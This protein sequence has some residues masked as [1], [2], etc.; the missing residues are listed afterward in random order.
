M[1]REGGSYSSLLLGVTEQSFHSAREGF[2]LEQTNMMPD[3][4]RGLTRRQPSKMLAETLVGNSG[5]LIDTVNT[6]T[7][8]FRTFVYDY[9]GKQYVVLYPAAASTTIVPM[10]Y[11]LTD[12]VWMNV[13]IDE[14]DS[15][16]ATRMQ[17]GISAIT[18]T[19]KDVLLA[20][21][22]DVPTVS[23]TDAWGAVGNQS[24][25]SIWIRAG[26]FARTYTVRIKKRSTGVTTEHSYTTPTAT[27]TGTLDTSGVPIFAADPAGG[28]QT[29]TEAIAITSSGGFGLGALTWGSWSPSSLSLKQNAT[30]LTNVSPSDPS[31]AS[32]YRWDAGSSTVK[33]HSSLV[34]ATNIS[35]TYTHTKT[36]SNPQ[37]TLTIAALTSAFNL[38]TAQHLVEATAAIQPAAIATALAGVLTTAGFTVTV[39]S[40][41]IEVDDASEVT[42]SDGAD[43]S[44]IRAVGATCASINDLPAYHESGKIVRV[45]ARETDDALYYKAV[46]RKSGDSGFVLVN[47]EETAGTV[48]TLD[49]KLLFGRA[50]GTDFYL[51][52]TSGHMNALTGL[53]DAPVYSSNECGDI[54][55]VPVP[56]FVGRVIRVLAVFQD[57][58]II[59]TAGVVRCSRIG[60]YFYLFRSTLL[61]VLAN[62]AFETSAKGREDDDI[63]FA[64]LYDQN[65]FLFGRDAQYALG[66][67]TAL[68]ALNPNLPVISSHKGAAFLPPVAA[69]STLFYIKQGDVAWSAHQLRPGVLVDTPESFPVSAQLDSYLDGQAIEAIGV[70]KPTMLMVRSKGNRR[71]LYTLNYQD[72]EQGRQQEA[73]HKWIYPSQ[74]GNLIGQASVDGGVVLF[75]VRPGNGNR[76]WAVADFQP[77]LANVASVPYLDS[78]R[79]YA[80]VLDGDNSITE[81]S[82]G[83]ISAAYNSTPAHALIGGILTDAA[84]LVVEFDDSENLVVGLDNDASYRPQSP[85]IRDSNGRVS[86]QGLLVVSSITVSFTNAGGLGYDLVTQA[87]TRS[88]TYSGRTLGA[89]DNIIGTEPITTGT[90][91]IPIGEET[92]RSTLTLRSRKWFPLTLSRLAW[93]GHY[94]NRTRVV[95]GG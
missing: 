91:D 77:L 8:D 72:S 53:T 63:R 37:Y 3:I 16:V 24:K 79:T 78:W 39:N 68:T 4:V 31:S 13:V 84:G 42:G 57:R 18:A 20:S 52:S 82:A 93:R 60:D 41:A 6:R 14:G 59:A 27:Y 81:A 74:G 80:N 88:D 28:T 33:V 17:S 49:L 55:S 94:F 30:T 25:A 12:Q 65:L 83:S 67:R 70:P 26:N 85:S 58:L 48:H 5:G 76:V 10:V 32:E 54:D 75:S 69:G 43:N 95:Q 47:W 86:M 66:G 46:P 11:N 21:Y 90:L 22:G 51:A 34:G 2:C 73:W 61:S 87:E 29:D 15:A 7:Q 89:V 23:S 71:A 38:A 62:D 44:S 92:E 1:S 40:T 64:V 56:T 50:H 35:V 9:S 36:I 45:R 19:G